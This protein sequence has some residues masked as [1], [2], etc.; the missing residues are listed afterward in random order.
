M[1]PGVGAK[2]P[3]GAVFPHKCHTGFEEYWPPVGC[4][5]LT[6]QIGVGANADQFQGRGRALVNYNHIW[7]KVAVSEFYACALQWVVPVFRWQRGTRQQ[8]R[9]Q[10]FE[11]RIQWRTSNPPREILFEACRQ[12]NLHDD[13]AGQGRPT[14]SGIGVRVSPP[15][16]LPSPH[17]E[18]AGG[19][20]RLI[21]PYRR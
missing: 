9:E 19:T 18:R 11:L 15:L 2:P 3:L 17:S 8:K 12:L 20:R 1:V 10:R 5:R 16:P 6:K 14:Y 21:L 7:A 4:F 13:G